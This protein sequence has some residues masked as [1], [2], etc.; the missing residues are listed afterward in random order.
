MKMVR[1]S[2]LR[3]G[4]LYPQERFLVL[5]SIRGW[6]DSRVKVRQEVLSHWKIPLTP[7]ALNRL[8]N[9]ILKNPRGPSSGITNPKDLSP[10]WEANT[11][12]VTQELTRILLNEGTLPHSQKPAT[13]HYVEPDRSS[14]CP[15]YHS[16]KIHFNTILHL[17]LVSFLQVAPLKP[18]MHLTSPPSVVHHHH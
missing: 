2:G 13:C 7:S 1:L 4:R 11:S 18:C 15:L 3:T 16:W 6:V 9:Y 8:Q 10:F 17:C 14:P 5:I 12:L